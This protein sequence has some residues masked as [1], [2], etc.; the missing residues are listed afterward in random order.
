M[1]N[2]NLSKIEKIPY[3]SKIKKIA[4]KQD[5]EVY[6]VGGVLRDIF[7]SGKIIKLDF[8]FA[9][10]KK[11][12]KFVRGFAKEVKGRIVVLDKVLRNI[13]VV[14]KKKGQ[15]LNYDF[16]VFRK[17]PFK[18]DIKKR[19]FTVNTLAVK[20][21][22][23]PA[24]KL[25][26]FASGLRDLN[27]KV[28]KCVSSHAFKDDALRIMRAYS[29]KAQYNFKIVR[30]TERL[31]VKDKDLLSKISPERI[32]EELFK[33]FKN[34]K[35]YSLIKDM[36]KSSVLTKIFPQINPMRGIGKAGYHHLD[37][38]D[39]SVETLRC[40]E[41]L[42]RR[43]VSRSQDIQKYLGVSVAQSRSRL[44]LIKFACLFHDIGKPKAMVQKKK[45]TLFHS[46]EKI[47]ADML[48]KICKNLRL[49]GK[50]TDFIKHLTFM[51]LRPGYL[52]DTKRP[53]KRAIF[54]YFRDAGEDAVGI[55]LLSLADW[56]ATRGPLT[57]LKK[58]RS[59]ERIM[60]YLID[61]Y[62]KEKKKPAEKRLV[63]GNDIMKSLDI[64]P[65]PLLGKILRIIDENQVLGKVKTKQQA[66]KLARHIYKQKT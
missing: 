53:S 39:H 61:E 7:L 37:V 28:V 56:R 12:E 65:S 43:K 10:E 49:S 23:Y 55:L 19:D 20:I 47:G 3:L 34:P 27:R 9:V 26:D 48:D 62:F 4:K 58:R 45:K 15:I 52:A 14:K 6:L 40:F 30:D 33:I 8:D 66:L 5:V 36:D 44:V 21:N 1:K 25:I 13:R 51:H 59:H 16:S 63:T 64:S 24:L 54:R 18:E 22:S 32:S 50:E 31:I 2:P 35:S 29:L 42:Y 11:V 17:Q 60:F 57:D 46:H 41:S 38:W